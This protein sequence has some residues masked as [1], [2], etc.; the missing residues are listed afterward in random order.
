MRSHVFALLALCTLSVFAIVGM[1]PETLVKFEAELSRLP[2][3]D[4]LTIL[5][6]P[7]TAPPDQNNI[8]LVHAE[9]LRASGAF[10][11]AE[12]V[13]GDLHTTLPGHA[14]ITRKLADIALIT[15]EREQALLHRAALYAAEP[16]AKDRETLGLLNRIGRDRAAEIGVLQSVPPEQLTA[17]EA[18]RLARL[19]SEAGRSGDVEHLYLALAGKRGPFRAE[20]RERLV[21]FLI[22]EGRND[23]A[24][25]LAAEWYAASDNDFEVIES[26]L[27]VFIA[28]G[29]IDEAVWLASRSLD[30]APATGHRLVRI[31]SRS[32]HRAIARR[33]QDAVLVQ[34]DGIAPEEWRTLIDFAALT[35][36][37]SGLHKAIA[38]SPRGT[39][40]EGALPEA[41]LNM[42]RYQ[43]SSALIPYFQLETE[44]FGR[45]APL[46]AAAFAV[47]QSR[48]DAAVRY[49]LDAAGTG[50]S[51]WDRDVWV[52]LAARLKGTG[53]DRLLASGPIATP[54]LA[55]AAQEI[56]RAP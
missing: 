27:A 50:L 46:V 6:N 11:E 36:D 1:Q 30:V 39:I 52:S 43:G 25:R 22:D 26:L 51:A 29:A 33:F 20:A 45:D 17:W 13:L 16:L 48:H 9:L 14:D 3:E 34:E 49:L 2:P 5:Q 4:A 31:F 53:Y 7:D 19:L 38:A 12:A 41:L 42:L 10:P 15:G 55:E 47:D 8:A 40:P 32:G 56:L 35:G 24:L 28:R 23:A 37:M 18:D 54:E 21:V 44:E